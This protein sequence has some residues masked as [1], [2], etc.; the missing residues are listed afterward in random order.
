MPLIFIYLYLPSTYT[1]FEHPHI[2]IEY[3]QQK[4]N[5]F[6]RVTTPDKQQIV[7]IKH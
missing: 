6:Q 1:T 7:E 3:F 4:Q 2:E 5:N